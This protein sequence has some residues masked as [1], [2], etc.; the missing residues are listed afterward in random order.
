M[1][2]FNMLWQE[3]VQEVQELIVP[4]WMQKVKLKFHVRDIMLY[5]AKSFSVQ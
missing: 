5:L 2:R 4:A 1:G 3:K